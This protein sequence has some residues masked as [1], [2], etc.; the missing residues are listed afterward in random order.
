[1]YNLMMFLNVYIT[2]FSDLCIINENSLVDSFYFLERENITHAR[3]RD[4][5]I[6]YFQINKCG[7]LQKWRGRTC[8][9]IFNKHSINL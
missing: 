9:F 6:K 3:A 8:F 4:I 7:H 5:V 2:K 1:M